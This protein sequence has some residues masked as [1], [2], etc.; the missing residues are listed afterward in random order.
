MLKF[1]LTEQSSVAVVRCLFQIWFDQLFGCQ[2]LHRGWHGRWWPLCSWPTSC[3]LNF[4][5]EGTSFVELSLKML[6]PLLSFDLKS[7]LTQQKSLP[8]IFLFLWDETPPSWMA[9]STE[10]WISLFL[11]KIGLE[12]ALSSLLD[13]FGNLSQLFLVL[14]DL[15]PHV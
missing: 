9:T 11:S 13:L 10:T 2:I 7:R 14:F 1:R 3:P 15:L 12:C 6:H 4:W 5:Y 8:V